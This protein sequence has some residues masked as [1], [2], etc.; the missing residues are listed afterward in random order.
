MLYHLINSQG[1]WILR[2]RSITLTLFHPVASQISFPFPRAYYPVQ[3]LTIK[4][5]LVGP[6]CCDKFRI[7]FIRNGSLNLKALFISILSP[8][9]S[10]MIWA[11]RLLAAMLMHRAR[12]SRSG[13]S[14]LSRSIFIAWSEEIKSQGLKTRK[15]RAVKSNTMYLHSLVRGDQKSGIKDQES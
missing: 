12:S 10:Q 15:A 2:Q 1:W 9:P 6:W 5:V 8:G 14:G 3:G 4:R 11:V 7:I 13:C